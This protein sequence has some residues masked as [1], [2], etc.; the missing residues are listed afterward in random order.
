[1]N[2]AFMATLLFLVPICS[3]RVWLTLCVAGAQAWAQQSSEV[4]NYLYYHDQAGKWAISTA[5]G[6]SAAVAAVGLADPTYPFLQTDPTFDCSG[7]NSFYNRPITITCTKYSIP[8]PANTHGTHPFC[9]PCTP[10]L[11]YAPP[12]SLSITACAR[13]PSTCS[14]I[15]IDGCT[16]TAPLTESFFGLN[17]DLHTGSCA[18]QTKNDQPYPVSALMA[19]A[20]AVHAVFPL[21]SHRVCGPLCSHRVCGR[22][23]STP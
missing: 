9:T 6:T 19:A 13:P 3:H 8:C 16:D 10:S 23:S 7:S 1:M 2:C 11:P 15:F 14:R 17:Y 12:N 5:C 21:C 22:C 18:Y 4:S 20:K